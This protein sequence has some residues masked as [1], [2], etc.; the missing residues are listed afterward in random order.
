MNIW[1]RAKKEYLEVFEEELKRGRVDKDIVWLIRKINLLEDYYTTSSCSGRIQVTANRVPG[2]KFNLIT[3]AKWHRVIKVEELSMV[4]DSS[5]EENLWFS[6]QP[7]IL[8]VICKDL[9]SAEKLLEIARNSGFKHS[10]IQ[11]LNPQRIVVEITSSERIESPL[12]LRGVEFMDKEKLQVLVNIANELLI[13]GKSR[14]VRLG[15]GLSSLTSRG[16]ILGKAHDSNT[17]SVRFNR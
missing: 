2:E 17:S 14:L 7:P 11:G 15:T 3:L 8:H 9:E 13:R 4:I 16:N 10:G 1:E 5:C 6:V 12:R